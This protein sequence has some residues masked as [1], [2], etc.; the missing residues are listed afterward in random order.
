MF[1][2]NISLSFDFRDLYINE[3]KHLRSLVSLQFNNNCIESLKPHQFLKNLEVLNFSNNL[4]DNVE[5][6]IYLRNMTKL[7]KLICF[8]NKFCQNEN[9][10]QK[11]RA[12]LVSTAEELYCYDIEFNSAEV[13]HALDLISKLFHK[14]G[15]IISQIFLALAHVPSPQLS[16]V[17]PIQYHYHY[18]NQLENYQQQELLQ[19]Y[20]LFLLE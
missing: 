4:V 16:M 18:F 1:Q 19:E 20:I 3:V 17:T 5:H 13:L 6:L 9:F 11:L 15:V 2:I 7:K 12:V 14:K 8:K 10:E